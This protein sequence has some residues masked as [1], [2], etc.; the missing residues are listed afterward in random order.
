MPWK[1]ALTAGKWT[2]VP[3]HASGRNASSTNP[4]TWAAF[5]EV[6]ATYRRGGC[7]GFGFVLG[8]GFTGIDLDDIRDRASGELVS[9]AASW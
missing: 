1:L 9:W 3:V 7:D 4:K 5:P 2:K 6:L 8:D